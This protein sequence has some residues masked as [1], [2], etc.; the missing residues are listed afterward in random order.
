MITEMTINGVDATIYGLV[1]DESALAVLMTPAGHK[2]DVSNDSRIE[3]GVRVLRKSEL[4]RQDKR[5]LSLKI[6]IVAQST[7]DFYTKYEKFCND[8]LATG[9]VDIKTAYQPSVIY[10]CRYRSCETL[11]YYNGKVGK[12]TL[13]LVEPDPTDR[14]EKSKY[15]TNENA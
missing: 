1:L 10:R 14:G 13:K 5:N 6:G 9:E 4:A 11:T 8:V 15:D 2:E 3:H 7:S 12:F